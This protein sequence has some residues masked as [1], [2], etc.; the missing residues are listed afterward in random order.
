MT[1]APEKIL[2]GDVGGTNIRLALASL[3]RSG[4]YLIE[5][6]VK[7]SGDD[8][9]GLEE[10][11]E[12]YLSETHAK[13]TQMCL[14]VAGPVID[15]RVVFSNRKWTITEAGLE[16]K[17]R[18]KGAKLVNDFAAM[19]RSVPKLPDEDFE[20][21]HDGH[22]VQGSPILVAGQG[23]GFGVSFLIPLHD[24]WHVINTEGGNQAYA[25]QTAEELE[26]LIILKKDH[27]Y[28]SLEMVSSGAG[29]DA[30]HR[31]VCER[32]GITY[33]KASPADIRTRALAGD[34]VCGEVCHVRAHATM[35]ALGDLALAGGAQGG[36]VLAGGVSAR[37]IDFLKTEQAIERFYKR[38][39]HTDYVKNIPIR[40]LVK[41]TA[42]LIGAAMLFT[43]K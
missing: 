3:G 18:L 41:P 26:L 1:N 30:L 5:G 35:G 21:I 6:F 19:A 29:L 24:S 14:A 7:Y 43:N 2:V 16:N 4:H 39:S 36:I 38:G 31:A 11:I 15:G 42:P 40:L 13:V 10:A 12:K 37:M 22:S 17:F 8:F 33:I 28:V 34:L 32:N 25:P 20:L 9:T 23:T 27:D